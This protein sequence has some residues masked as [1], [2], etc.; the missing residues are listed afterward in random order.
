M[1]RAVVYIN[2]GSRNLTKTFQSPITNLQ[3]RIPTNE[4]QIDAATM[5]S[6][7]VHSF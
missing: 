5:V 2:N 1:G 7:F 4:I 6:A 3:S